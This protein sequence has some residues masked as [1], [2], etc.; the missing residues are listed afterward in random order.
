MPI[1]ASQIVEDRLQRDGRRAIRERHVDSLAGV[2][3]VAYLAEAGVDA[4]TVMAARVAS[5]ETGL[6]EGEHNANLSR[7]LE[8]LLPVLRHTTIA[9]F[10]ARLRVFYRDARGWA[11]ARLGKF[12]QSLGLS[13]AQLT[14]LFG[15]SGAQLTALKNRL[16]AQAARYDAVTAD[17]GE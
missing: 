2:H 8:Q 15:V 4:S 11:A 1:T 14:A 13:D 12:V 16:A 17:Q 7:A 6:A 5:L 3:E 10:R 9:Q